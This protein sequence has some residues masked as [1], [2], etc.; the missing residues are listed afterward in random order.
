[1]TLSIIIVNYNVKQLLENCLNTV[2][3]AII[4]I[5]AEVIVVDNAS[6]DNSIEHLQPLFPQFRFIANTVNE[7][8]AK[9]NNRGLAVCQGKFVLFLNPDTLLPPDSLVK[10]I[11]F[12]E[13]HPYA[14]ALGVR[15]VDGKGAFL[16]ESKRG[17]PTP[18]VS[19]FKLTGI[20]GMFPRSPFFARY[21]LGHLAENRD[22]EVDVLS[23]AFM[24]VKKSV[25]ERTGSFDE[26]FFM[27]AE[28]ID[29]SYR[30]QHAGY[31]N[32]YFA[33]T[34]I[35]HFKG[36]STKKDLKYVRLFYKAMAQFSKK[37][38]GRG[39]YSLLLDAGI[40]VFTVFSSLR[41]FFS[42]KTSRRANVLLP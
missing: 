12:L 4:N 2:S 5:Q 9:A 1:V 39:F 20:T 26:R 29:L 30:I 8:F 25:I 38:Y 24:M 3:K 31:K 18:L 36:G 28:D 10:C 34:T 19:L 32:F 41:V 33:G 40:G 16:K 17:F 11:D 14:G 22:H 13:I 7:G 42:G 37:Y 23:G 21:Y 35:T 6:T 15:M 27:Y